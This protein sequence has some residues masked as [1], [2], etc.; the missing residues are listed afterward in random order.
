M[1]FASH[2]TMTFKRI[3]CGWARARARV[4]V[5]VYVHACVRVCVCAPENTRLTRIS[6]TVPG[7][8]EA[9]KPWSQV[10]VYQ[11]SSLK[12]LLDSDRVNYQDQELPRLAG[13]EYNPD[14]WTLRIRV[15]HLFSSTPDVNSAVDI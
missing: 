4:C 6:T 13:I 5:R 3:L 1:T 2:Y 7:H 8:S 12:Q 11:Q 9:Q 15:L 14:V 10:S